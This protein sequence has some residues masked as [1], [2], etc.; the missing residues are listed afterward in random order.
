MSSDKTTNLALHKWAG[1]DPVER[2]EFN[3][4][5]DIIDSKIGEQIVK[6]ADKAYVDTQLAAVN[7]GPKGTYATLVALQTAFPTGNA[8]NYL[9]AAD[10]KWYYWSG[11]AWTAGGQYQSSG[12]AADSINTASIATGAVRGDKLDQ[13]LGTHTITYNTNGTVASVTTPEGTTTFTYTNG[14]ITNVVE[15]IY[16]VT[17]N[18]VITYYSDGTV[19]SATRS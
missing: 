12:I 5:F 17:V 13:V 6:K 16:G 9:V 19:A 14:R 15:T 8:N 10:G 4:N 18:T 3:D 1:T 7:G 2:T 11:T